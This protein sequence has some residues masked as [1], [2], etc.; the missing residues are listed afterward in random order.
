MKCLYC[1]KEKT[2]DKYIKVQI[3]NR[4]LWFC[5]QGCLLTWL[6]LNRK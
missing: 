6:Q 2:K 1:N 3:E 4:T 5:C